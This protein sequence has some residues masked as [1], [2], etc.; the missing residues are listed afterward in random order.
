V[1][2]SGESATPPSATFV[3]AHVSAAAAAPVNGIYT[4]KGLLS[5]RKKHVR[6]EAY[7]SCA[8]PS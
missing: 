5:D 3:S 1:G 4:F 7:R 8:A 6:R 2:E